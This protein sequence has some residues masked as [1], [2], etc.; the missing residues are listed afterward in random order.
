MSPQKITTGRHADME[1]AALSFREVGLGPAQ[2]ADML[3]SI[4]KVRHDPPLP[5][6]DIEKIAAGWRALYHTKDEFLNVK[7]ASF[8]IKDFLLSGGVTAIAGP[9]GQRKTLIA[10]NIVES[11]L[12]G[13]PLF[14][15]FDVTEKPSKVFYL[16]PEMGLST[17]GKR[18][19]LLGLSDYVGES[20]FIQTLNS[21]SPV[22]LSDL[23]TEL[24]GSVIFLD[25]AVR[26]LTGNE[27]DSS[28]MRLFAAQVFALMKLGPLAIVIL[29]HSTKG[30]NDASLTLDNAMRGSTEL[31]AFVSCCWATRLLDPEEPYAS[32]SILKN[33]KQRDFQ[34][35][36]FTITSSDSGRLSI[37]GKPGDDSVTIT[38]KGGNKDGKHDAALQILRDNPDLSLR[39]TVAALKKAGIGRGKDWVKQRRYELL[40]ERGGCLSSP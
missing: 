38:I 34:T 29:Y 25:T 2:F 14:G 23:G 11:L 21:E 18:F 20:L 33:V 17:L 12:T 6:A 19:K 5:R 24:Y 30:S 15:H 8:L 39:D 28:D 4:S 37:A 31:A 40:Q 7:P 10:V 13:N 26:F 27:N 36:P 35:D 9:V 3:E 1:R 32:P 22:A 16:C